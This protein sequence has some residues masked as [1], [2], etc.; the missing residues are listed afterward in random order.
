MIDLIERG[1]IKDPAVVLAL[2]YIIPRVRNALSQML[3]H[4]G[5]QLLTPIGSVM[6][7][8]AGS[9]VPPGWLLCDGQAVSR[10]TYAALF[11]VIG[12]T[13]GAGNGSTSFNVPTLS[14][15]PF[16]AIIFAGV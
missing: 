9:V 8:F 3:D 14:N 12:A 13:Y 11:R 10:T 2:E 4:E 5:R 15:P 16:L 6:P 7:F 1:N